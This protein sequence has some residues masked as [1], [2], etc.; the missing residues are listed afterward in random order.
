MEPLLTLLQNHSSGTSRW[1]KEAE[2]ECELPEEMPCILATIATQEG[3]S[4]IVGM[5]GKPPSQREMDMANI[6]EA[7]GMTG[8]ISGKTVH[9]FFIAGSEQCDH[10]RNGTS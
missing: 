1:S 7:R 9:V 6:G 10:T 4:P 8:A 2:H 5:V 3:K